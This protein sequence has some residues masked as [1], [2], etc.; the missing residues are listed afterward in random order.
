MLGD[1]MQKKY[2]SLA[3]KIKNEKAT[4]F[5][6]ISRLEKIEEFL[7]ENEKNWTIKDDKIQFTNL[8][9]MTEYY[10]LLNKLVD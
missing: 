3:E 8:T 2:S 9:K 6:K 1:A 4:L 7:I 5:E 10:N